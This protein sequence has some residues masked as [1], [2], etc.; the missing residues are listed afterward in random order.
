MFNEADMNAGYA[1]YEMLSVDKLSFGFT[2]KCEIELE[3]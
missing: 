2:R 1:L 3:E